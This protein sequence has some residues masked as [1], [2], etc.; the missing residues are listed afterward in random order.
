MRTR[1]EVVVGRHIAEA[2]R[3]AGW[4]QATLAERCGISTLTLGRIERGTQAT[5]LARLEQIADVLGLPLADLVQRRERQGRHGR[6]VE[7][8]VGVVRGLS[9][10][11]AELVAELAA[12]VARAR[13]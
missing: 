8:L 12:C 11:E 7:Q 3:A 10:E 2:R 4:T 5:A 1:I 13:R 6:A 9:A